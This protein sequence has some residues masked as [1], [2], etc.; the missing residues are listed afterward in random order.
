MKIRP[1]YKEHPDKA[2]N[3]NPLTEC[4]QPILD[5]KKIESLLEHTPEFSENFHDLPTLYKSTNIRRISEFYIPPMLA[6]SLY[7]KII[8]L[9][10]DG[11]RF[12]NPFTVNMTR[13]LEDMADRKQ[14]IQDECKEDET[15]AY[16]IIPPGLTIAPGSLLWGPS[17][18]G[19]TSLL[20]LI[21]EIIPQVVVHN[22]YGDRKDFRQDQLVWV[23]F[24]APVTSS[25]KMLVINFMAAVDKAL[26]TNYHTDAIRR[27]DNTSYEIF[28][29]EA[30][31]II[32]NHYIGIA[33]IDEL[34]FF[35]NH[36]KHKD[37][38]SLQMIEA[39]FNKLGV[40]LFIT[41]T[42]EGLPLIEMNDE[43]K[44][45]FVSEKVF[46]LN[47][48]VY[49]NKH[50]NA[51]IE[52]VFTPTIWGGDVLN[53]H[54]EFLYQFYFLSAGLQA[55]MMR[56]ARLHLEYCVQLDRPPFDIDT[57]N[58]VFESQ[59]GFMKTSLDNLREGNTHLYEENLKRN[60]KGRP[61]WSQTEMDKSTDAEGADETSDHTD[62][63]SSP[64]PS[65]T[66]VTQTTKKTV[67]DFHSPGLIGLG[68]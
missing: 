25:P 27:Y 46:K 56:L 16:Q 55:V 49:G 48:L 29:M 28:I 15:P 60:K 20:R 6:V 45:R 53:D 12:R 44:R 50:F 30:Q 17:G 34:Q 2:F 39:M 36:K 37:S 68:S 67:E 14:L 66:Q 10:L 64:E 41:T 11:Y 38:P 24:D 22:G 3:G 4:I 1:V 61:H 19:K 58:S 51:F 43:T 65:A 8:E 32:A 18:S 26:K 42:E 35:L 52:K 54:E 5:A 23:S 63:T 59:F 21:L 57:L 33:H 7:Y 31:E 40:P 13:F 9:I 62:N 47:S